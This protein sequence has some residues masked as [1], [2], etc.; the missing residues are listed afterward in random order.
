MGEVDVQVQVHDDHY[1]PMVAALALLEPGEQVDFFNTEI[2]LGSVGMRS[3]IT[4][5]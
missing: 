5:A 3:F 1:R 4:A 2:D